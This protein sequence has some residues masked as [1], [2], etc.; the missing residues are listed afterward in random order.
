[1]QRRLAE[2]GLNYIPSYRAGSLAEALAIYRA[3]FNTKPVVVK[4]PRSGGSEGIRLCYTE[5]DIICHFKKF[6]GA[7]NLENLRNSDL[8]IQEFLSTHDTEI[9]VNTVSLKGKHFVTDIWRSESKSRSDKQFFVYSSQHL[10]LPNNPIVSIILE[11]T[12]SVLDALGMESGASHI[13]LAAKTVPGSGLIHELVLI[14][15]NPRAAG[16]I[17]TSNAVIPGWKH[18]DQIYWLVMSLVDPNRFAT[19]TSMYDNPIAVHKYGANID[20]ISVFLNNFHGT[21]S[22]R[23][24]AKILWQIRTD[25]KSFS[26]FGRG[27]TW[28]NSVRSIDEVLVNN[29]K[30]HAP[31]T[32]DLITSPG[33]ILLVGESAKRDMEIIKSFES[34]SL[35]I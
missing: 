16:E 31:Q 12:F 34:R 9:I 25:L 23:L 24:N 7:M 5:G 30:L 13:E 32:V 22:K 29:K 21:G 8:V 14:E 11:Y 4:P 27:L 2:Q 35:Y 33:V 19:F 17:R 28:L 18:F 26:R 15:I 10:V 1:M 20:V 3:R 6:L